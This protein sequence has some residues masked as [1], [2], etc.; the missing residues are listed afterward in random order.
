MITVSVDS[1]Q[2]LVLESHGIKCWNNFNILTRVE[3]H[4]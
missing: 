2:Q 3:F 1:S 4:I